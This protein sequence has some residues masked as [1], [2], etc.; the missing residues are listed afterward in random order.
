M[1]TWDLDSLRQ[2]LQKEEGWD[3]GSILP[4]A[5]K[6]G[7]AEP[8]LVPA[9]PD[10]LR[11]ALLGGVD[12]LEGPQTGEMTPEAT[13]TLAGLAGSSAF[14]RPTEGLLNVLI[15]PKAK[16]FEPHR[17]QAEA[18]RELFARRDVPDAEKRG[19]LESS[20]F[21]MGLHSELQ[22]AK[23]MPELGFRGDE[24]Q[25]GKQLRHSLGGM[26]GL[27]EDYP[28]LGRT[29]LQ[30]TAPGAKHLGSF[31]GDEIEL[32][33]NQSDE[34]LLRT[35]RHELQHG[36]QREEGWPSGSNQQV[37]GESIHQA[38]EQGAGLDLIEA[39][40]ENPLSAYSREIGEQEA[41]AVMGMGARSPRPTYDSFSEGEWLQ[42]YGAREA[43]RP[44]LSLPDR[45][46]PD[47]AIPLLRRF[48]EVTGWPE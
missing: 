33:P 36:I 43:G 21:E 14:S 44:V 9:L 8:E 42:Q 47:W 3:Y 27:F 39:L 29:K 25:V 10:A 38:H 7:S 45:K 5:S 30:F 2:M 22:L 16:S 35:L 17:A 6:K 26:E 40:G 18:L 15:G 46:M 19:L 28:S 32:N 11:E 48:G 1:A 4:M 24:P 34:D 41:R 37:A 23:P 20:P 12:L 13:R 31:R